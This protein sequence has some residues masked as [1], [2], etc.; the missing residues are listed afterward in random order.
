MKTVIAWSCCC[1]LVIHNVRS[2]I[3]FVDHSLEHD[4]AGFARQLRS[5][6]H[7]LRNACLKF[8][9]V[10][11]HGANECMDPL[12]LGLGIEALRSAALFLSRCPACPDC[13]QHTC[14][15]TLSCAGPNTVEQPAASTGGVSG[16]W[17]GFCLGLLVAGGAIFS[18]F[19]FR[20]DQPEPRV[21]TLLPRPPAGHNTPAIDNDRRGAYIGPGATPGPH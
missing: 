2:P 7:R 15:P 10:Q 16:L 20:S 1:V 14:A 6:K 21:R 3:L 18:F 12:W 5:M 11:T 17:V 9:V 8:F 4:R 13:P 19:S